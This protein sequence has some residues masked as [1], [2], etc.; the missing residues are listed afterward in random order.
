MFT[1]TLDFV[2]I[3]S[4][5]D[6]V[7]LLGLA[8]FTVMLDFVG[9]LCDDDEVINNF[10]VMLDPRNFRRSDIHANAATLKI[11]RCSFKRISSQTRQLKF[12]NTSKYKSVTRS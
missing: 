12:C 7:I 3:L 9:N 11:R 6:D 5:G 8:K 10:D 4:D 2:G 1:V